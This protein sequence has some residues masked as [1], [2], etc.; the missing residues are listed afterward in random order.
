MSLS[1]RP[2]YLETSEP[3]SRLIRL[4]Y[5]ASAAM[6]GNLRPERSIVYLTDYLRDDFGCSEEEA[7][8]LLH[9]GLGITE[10][11]YRSDGSEFVQLVRLAPLK[12]GQLIEIAYPEPDH[13]QFL[14]DWYD[15][16]AKTALAGAEEHMAH[17]IICYLPPNETGCQYSRVCP[18][19]A[20]RNILIAEALHGRHEGDPTYQ[21]VTGSLLFGATVRCKLEAAYRCQL[22][23]QLERG[24]IWQMYQN[25]GH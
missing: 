22:I 8:R 17:R 6:D 2:N 19:K 13:Q 25:G 10:E 12:L 14:I 5:F 15:L 21:A 11:I 18:P 1:E 16:A 7:A 23:G 3:N 9:N 24:A 20:A 4:R